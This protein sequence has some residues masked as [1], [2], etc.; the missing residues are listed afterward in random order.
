MTVY[1]TLDQVLEI[2]AEVIRLHGGDPAIHDIRLVD[3]AVAQPQMTFGGQDLY[4][5][6]AEK[7]AAPGHSLTANHGFK[8][9]NKRVGFTAMDVFLRVNGCKIAAPVDEV[10]GVI[11]AVASNTI[12]RE[13]FTDWVRHH[14]VPV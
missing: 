9:G 11:L 5:S 13:R 3:P 8:D 6:L 2:H 14:T 10:E 7:A 1:L 12:T 4:P